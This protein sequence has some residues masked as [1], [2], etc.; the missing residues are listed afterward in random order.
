M[1]LYAPPKP[2]GGTAAN[3]IR[4]H[5]RFTNFRTSVGKKPVRPPPAKSLAKLAVRERPH[6]PESQIYI[7]DGCSHVAGEPAYW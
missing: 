3:T 6:S 4:A 7:P 1:L 5:D 2:N